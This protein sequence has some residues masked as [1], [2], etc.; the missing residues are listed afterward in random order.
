MV[1]LSRTLT[2]THTDKHTQVKYRLC[3]PQKILLTVTLMVYVL[4][5]SISGGF[6]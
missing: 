6:Y 2:Q 3:A 1:I 4:T 5:L